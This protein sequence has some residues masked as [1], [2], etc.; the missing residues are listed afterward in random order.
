VLAV[1]VSENRRVT[2]EEASALVEA[3]EA[4]NT[5]VPDQEL[6][7]FLQEI[8]HTV[9]ATVQ[10]QETPWRR[11]LRE[12]AEEAEGGG[13]RA[14]E[15][16]RLI[17]ARSP[18]QNLDE[19]VSDFRYRIKRLKE[20][21]EELEAAGNPWP[22]A[23]FSVL[24]DPDRLGE[25]EAL[26]ASARERAR[27][28]PEIPPGPSLD[29]LKQELPKLVIRA[30]DQ[31]VNTQRAEYN[32]LYVWSPDGT[33]AGILLRAAGRT[34]KAQED[35]KRVAL[36]S[37][38]AFADEFIQALSS[39][40]AGA[41]RERWWSADI[42]LVEGIQ[43]LSETERAQEE[44]FHLM[45]A[46]RRRKA[47][48]MLSGDRLPADLTALDDR[49]KGRIE[50]GLVVEVPVAAGDLSA[51]LEE[52]LPERQ[53]PSD[54]PEAVEEDVT[55]KDREWI[56]SFQPVGGWG[57]K[58]TGG[59]L[60]E[61]SVLAVPGAPREDGPG[62]DEPWLPS[63]EQVVMDWPRLEDRVAEELR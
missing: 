7:Q 63:S 48:I 37:V 27:P 45:E 6:G 53:A 41:W 28:F 50:G 62:T 8:S 46:L 33:A 14:D 24:R 12:L 42:L 40:V 49:L 1:Q 39:G 10:A 30:A 20:I 29:D 51:E 13:F 16:R 25:G 21:G 34:S 9:A 2:A 38:A 4:E 18:P 23:A 43:A 31:L 47:R 32:P 44:I 5:G 26:L 54:A 57:A 61:G 56:K 22:E 35:K 60:D 15:L 52:T 58:A 19:V 11:T 17:D 59:V 55:D 3:A 36:V